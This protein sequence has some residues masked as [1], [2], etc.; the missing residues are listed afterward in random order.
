MTAEA[1]YPAGP[2]TPEHWLED[3]A[4]HR[5][6]FEQSVFQWEHADAVRSAVQ[7]TKGRTEFTQPKHITLLEEALNRRLWLEGQ[8]AGV[9]ANLMRSAW[10][11]LPGDMHRAALE[12]LD[13]TPDDEK[14]LFFHRP[15]SNSYELMPSMARVLRG[16]P[17]PSP[18]TKAW[19]LYQLECVHRAACKILEDTLCDLVDEL[20]PTHGW[21]NLALMTKYRSTRGLQVR[22]EYQRELRGLPGDERRIHHQ[23]YQGTRSHWG[24]FA[25]R[26]T[27]PVQRPAP[28]TP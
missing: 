3:M 21:A 20:V 11:E 23:T 6:M 16:F 18:L 26:Y 10:R 24:H 7:A 8:C 14:I 19:E 28:V 25:E 22:V 4:W 13:M 12:V 9:R 5:L 2:R 17:C 1:Y 27:P 15:S